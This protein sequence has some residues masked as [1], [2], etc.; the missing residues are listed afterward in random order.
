MQE[1]KGTKKTQQV[2]FENRKSCKSF[3]IND[4]AVAQM[5]RASDFE[6]AGCEFDSHQPH[7][8]YSFGKIKRRMI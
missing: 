5:D 4:A 8:I 2:I 6:S 1:K 7:Q 3:I